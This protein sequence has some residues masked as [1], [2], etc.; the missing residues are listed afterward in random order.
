MKYERCGRCEI[1]YKPVGEPYCEI[2]RREITGEWTDDEKEEKSVCPYCGIHTL[3][4]GE[5][6]CRFC[7]N[8]KSS[9]PY[10]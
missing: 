10:S 6:C 4:S 5:E 8:G 2:C 9:Y 1:N 3:L 7:R